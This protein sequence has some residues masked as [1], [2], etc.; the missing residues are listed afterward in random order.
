MNRSGNNFMFGGGRPGSQLLKNP[1][2]VTKRQ[3][4][5]MLK[6]YNNRTLNRKD[7]DPLNDVIYEKEHYPN[8]VFDND[9]CCIYFYNKLQKRKTND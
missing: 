3:L 6:L 9:N 5:Y 4:L 1:A 7:I 2:G 8:I